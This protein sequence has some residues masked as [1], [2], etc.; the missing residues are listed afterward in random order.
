MD[1]VGCPGCGER[2]DLSEPWPPSYRCPH[3]RHQ[4]TVDLTQ[5]WRAISGGQIIGMMVGILLSLFCFGP[6]AVGVFFAWTAF[7]EGLP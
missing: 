7:L 4:L 6:V 2:L 1:E 3:C 5:R